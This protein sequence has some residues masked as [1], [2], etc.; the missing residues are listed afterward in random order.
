[1]LLR[2]FLTLASVLAAF[3][4]C[5]GGAGT[6]VNPSPGGAGGVVS[7]T[8]SSQGSL[9]SGGKVA[10]VWEVSSGDPDYAYIFGTG[11]VQG[12][13]ASLSFEAAPP[14]D[15]L[16][17]G[18]FGLGLVIVV[19]QST[20]LPDGKMKGELTFPISA[21][22][23]DYAVIYRNTTETLLENGWDKD[24]P[25]GYAC[26]QCVHHDSGFDTFAVVDCSAVKLV[27]YSK[28]LKGCNWT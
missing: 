9:P 5:S 15:A 7:V 6:P 11:S 28:G 24:F 18:K 3:V 10:V 14:A 20:P 25:Q 17:A 21:A 27:P 8:A 19:D 26:G 2:R 4:A 22:A 12:A 23:P 16:N 1:M 13:Q